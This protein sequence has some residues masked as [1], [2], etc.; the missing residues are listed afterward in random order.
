MIQ[1]PDSI[2]RLLSQYRNPVTLFDGPASALPILNSLPETAMIM[3]LIETISQDPVSGLLVLCK[4][5][6]CG[7]DPSCQASPGLI[8]I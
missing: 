2:A 3:A 8:K 6:H 4:W 5:F 7:Q 1:N